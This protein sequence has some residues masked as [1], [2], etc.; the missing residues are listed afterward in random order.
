MT[1]H[2]AVIDVYD[3]DQRVGVK[4]GHRLIETATGSN[5]SKVDPDSRV[6]SETTP[7][8]PE[9]NRDLSGGPDPLARGERRLKAREGPGDFGRAARAQIDHL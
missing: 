4:R 9:H 7:I 8:L 2:E 5:G 3:H 6:E 1:A